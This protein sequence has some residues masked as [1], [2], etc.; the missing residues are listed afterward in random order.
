MED[1]CVVM[2]Y[3]GGVC[4]CV[5]DSVDDG[6]VVMLYRGGLCVCVTVWRMVVL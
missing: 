2:L 5:C 4:V 6:C 3:R 1:G